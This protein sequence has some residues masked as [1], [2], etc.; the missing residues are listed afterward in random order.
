MTIL[1]PT[2][3]DRLPLQGALARHSLARIAPLALLHLGALA[4]MLWSEVNLLSMAVFALAWGFVNSLWLALLR[5]PALAAAL[6]LAIFAVLILVSRFKFDVLW[7][8]LNF[9]DVMIIDADTFAFLM[10]MFPNVRTASI[11]A[12]LVFIPLAIAAWRL[13]PFRVR[14]GAAALGSVACLAGIAG[15]SLA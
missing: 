8:S 3:P 2:R 5:R 1:S 10:A 12:A 13:D 15:L 4:I 6:S 9:I 14:R 7:M 11:V